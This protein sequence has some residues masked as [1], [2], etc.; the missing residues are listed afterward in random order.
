MAAVVFP[1]VWEIYL[2]LHQAKVIMAVLE[3]ELLEL[4]QLQEGAVAL[5]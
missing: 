5:G 1:A 4:L 2:G 3:P